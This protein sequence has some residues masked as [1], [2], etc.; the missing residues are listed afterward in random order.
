M[1][2][3][4]SS[5]LLFVFPV[6]RDELDPWLLCPASLLCLSVSISSIIKGSC[7]MYRADRGYSVRPLGYSFVEYLQIYFPPLSPSYPNLLLRRPGPQLSSQH[8][9]LILKRVELIE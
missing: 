7:H 1:I 6:L 9:D 5:H 4:F 8:L 2:L 3:I